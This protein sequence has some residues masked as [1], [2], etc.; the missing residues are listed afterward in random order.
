MTEERMQLFVQQK[1]G[2]TALDDKDKDA[3]G[4]ISM[5]GLCAPQQ[6]QL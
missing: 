3:Q 6:K 2:E 5:P 4:Q 1:H